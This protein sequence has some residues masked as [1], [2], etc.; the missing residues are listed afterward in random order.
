MKK[1]LCVTTALILILAAIII[2]WFAYIIFFEASEAPEMRTINAEDL[3]NIE[4]PDW[5][6]V[7]YIE[8]GNP[9]RSGRKLFAADDI[10]IHYVGNP[11]STAQNNRDYFASWN[12]S[13]CSHFVVGLEGEIIMCLPLNEQSIASNQRNIDTISIEVCHPDETGKFNDATY[14]SL[15]TLTAWLL[16]VCHLDSTNVIRHYDI[17][18]KDCPR[19]FVQHEDA[20]RRFLEDVRLRKR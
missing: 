6:D 18:G 20:W 13:V 4:I 12:S 7:Q 5:I 15:L 2:W 8:P 1:F 10:V 17:T 19:Y 14:D 3:A 11:M 16:D 9:S